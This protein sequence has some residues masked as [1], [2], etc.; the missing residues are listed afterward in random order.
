MAADVANFLTTTNILVHELGEIGAF[1][2]KFWREILENL[3]DAIENI[4]RN[5]CIN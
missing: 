1:Y 4:V 3:A 5:V 2:S